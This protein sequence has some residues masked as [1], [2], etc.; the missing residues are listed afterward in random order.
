MGYWIGITKRRG[1]YHEMQFAATSKPHSIGDLDFSKISSE[2][3]VLVASD[4]T[5]VV[6]AP[7]FRILDP[8]H[9]D[10]LF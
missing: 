6:K 2:Y 3:R 9:K 4:G 7:A 5:G 10:F 1:Y 8:E